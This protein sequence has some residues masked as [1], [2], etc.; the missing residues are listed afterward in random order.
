[1]IKQPTPP[2]TPRSRPR[3]RPPK[4]PQPKTQP[5]TP[6]TP[7]QTP[8]HQG[9]K[10]KLDDEIFNIWYNYLWCK[11]TQEKRELNN[12]KNFRFITSGK[13]SR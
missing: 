4:A 10:I 2:P 11:S 5:P 9:Q 8:K 12:I 6:P 1:M 3:G 13:R 7:Q